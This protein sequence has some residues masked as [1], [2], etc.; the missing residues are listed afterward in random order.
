MLLFGLALLIGLAKPGYS[1]MAAIVILLPAQRFTRPSG[2]WVYAAAAV[3]L[4]VVPA[5]LWMEFVSS[6]D[7]LPA[8]HR[9]DPAGQLGFLVAHPFAFA[10]VAARSLLEDGIDYVKSLVGVLGLYNIWLPAWV[11]FIACATLVVASTADG[12]DP[13]TNTVGAR[14]W[15]LALG[16]AN[17]LAVLLACYV[18]WSPARGVN[19]REK[20][21]AIAADQLGRDHVREATMDPCPSEPGPPG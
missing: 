17:V 7:P 12:D 19:L 1:F 9:A 16:L 4:A 18:W 20:S 11:Y 3:A 8:R 13:P 10:G 5:L 2:R 21:V 15:L 6:A 14:S